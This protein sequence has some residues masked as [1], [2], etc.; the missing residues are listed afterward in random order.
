MRV[1]N[2]NSQLYI[3]NLA[4]SICKDPASLENWR[5]L[6]IKAKDDSTYESSEIEINKLKAIHKNIECDIVHCSDNDIFLI[7][8]ELFAEQLCDLAYELMDVDSRVGESGKGNAIPNDIHIYDL[9][10]DWRVIRALLFEKTGE[11]PQI[12]AIESD[13]NSAEDI[14]CNAYDFSAFEDVFKE[15]RK[16]RVARDPAHVMI[17][18]DDPL[19]KRIVS[20]CFKENYAIISAANAEEAVSNYLLYA[21]DIVFLDIGLPDVSGFQVLQQIIKIDP[22]AYIVMFSSNS[23]LDNITNAL[24]CGASGFVAK[25]FRK[26]KMQHYIE[27]SALHHRKKG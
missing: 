26:E 9:F 7:S 11:V 5:C 21:P 8:R 18:E 1:Y 3:K 15:A 16:L 25:P 24:N 10:R 27:D 14:D 2:N 17:V 20:N 19:T 6:H 12:P 4:T 23:Y 13:S 22:D